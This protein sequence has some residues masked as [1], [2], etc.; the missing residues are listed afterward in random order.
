MYERVTPEKLESIVLTPSKE[1]R[2]VFIIN[3]REG[4]FT[5]AGPMIS[6]QDWEVSRYIF[7]IEKDQKKF[8]NDCKHI[9]DTIAGKAVEYASAFYKKVRI[10]RSYLKSMIV[11]IVEYN[12]RKG[13]AMIETE[14]FNI[15]QK[16]VS[17]ETTYRIGTRFTEDGKDISLTLDDFEK[18]FKK[19]DKFMPVYLLST[20]IFDSEEI[21]IVVTFKSL[22]IIKDPVVEEKKKKAKYVYPDADDSD[23]EEE[24]DEEQKP[25]P[26]PAPPVE[27]KKEETVAVAP[28]PPVEK[29]ASSAPRKVIK[30]KNKK[31]RDVFPEDDEE[32]QVFD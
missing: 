2:N 9:V 14:L 28:P 5:F 11:P 25:V 8:T 32:L 7:R 20:V 10:S 18:R 27:I 12:E 26:T 29:E 3:A 1:K 15:K 4:K 24:P 13:T 6:F 30:S 21:H 17:G 31:K 23:L 16:E 22:Q 19:G